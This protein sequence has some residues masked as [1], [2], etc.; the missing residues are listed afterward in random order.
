MVRSVV[1]DHV[2]DYTQEDLSKSARRYD[3]IFDCVGNHSL[4]E[5]RCV[6]NPKGICVMVGDLSGRGA[7]ALLARLAAVLLSGFLDPKFV[8]FLARPDKE[9][10]TVMRELM[11]AG[12]ITPVIDKRYSLREGPQAFSYLAGKH[13]RGKGVITVEDSDKT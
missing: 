2:I 4:S 11:K 10:L 7:M 6:L 12:R 1:A 13:A 3:L 9:D 5:L 8:T